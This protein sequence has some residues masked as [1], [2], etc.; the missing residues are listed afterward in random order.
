M[1]PKMNLYLVQYG[2]EPDYVE[3]QTFREAIIIWQ[4]HMELEEDDDWDKD[5]EPQSVALVHDKAV[6]R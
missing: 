5:T 4:R 2:G 1:E 6:W 3:A